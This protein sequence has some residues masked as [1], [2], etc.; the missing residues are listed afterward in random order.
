M[1]KLRREL[2]ITDDGSH[3]FYLPDLD[4][5]YHSTHGAIQESVHIYLDA[6]FRFSDKNPVNILEIGFGTGLNCYLTAMDAGMKNRKVIYHSI[7][8]YLL[9]MELINKLNY[10]NLN[11][12][13]AARLFNNLHTCEWNKDIPINDDFILRK[14]EGDLTTYQFSEKYDIIY[15]DAFAPDVQP[16]LWK[17][18]IFKKLY[19]STNQSAIL[20]TY[21]TKGIVKRALREAGFIVKRLPGPPGKREMLRATKIDDFRPN[22]N[23]VEM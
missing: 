6:G 17:P 16:E 4:E 7:E 14:I 12:I 20:T 8:L 22:T 15:F 9:N 11:D 5:H 23:E 13:E 21:C 18:E 19:D 2:K 1:K 10:A 3:T